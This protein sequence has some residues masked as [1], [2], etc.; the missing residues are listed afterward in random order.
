MRA[1]QRGIDASSTS[2]SSP[3]TTFAE[4]CAAG[5]DLVEGDVSG[6]PAGTRGPNAPAA[7]PGHVRSALFQHANVYVYPFYR[8]VSLC[9][10]EAASAKPRQNPSEAVLPGTECYLPPRIQ[11]D[12]GLKLTPA[13]CSRSP[14]P[15]AFTMNRTPTRKLLV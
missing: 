5:I 12:A 6:A 15:T 14:R 11:Y 8:A 9:Y 10:P 1:A 3:S 13:A 2:G 7:Q 4:N